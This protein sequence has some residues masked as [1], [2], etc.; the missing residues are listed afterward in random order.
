MTN[1]IRRTLVAIRGG[2]GGAGIWLANATG[3]L[4]IDRQ[5]GVGEPIASD[6]IRVVTAAAATVNSNE[7]GVTIYANNADASVVVTLPAIATVGL[8]FRVRVVVKALPAAGAGTTVT[9]AAADKFQ[10]NGFNAK[11]DGQTLVNSAVSDAIGDLV[12]LQSDV[13]GWFVIGKVGTWA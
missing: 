5:G 3:R 4:F 10:G 8:G 2:T 12:D 7:D 1:M 6:A 13:D 9:P 11:T